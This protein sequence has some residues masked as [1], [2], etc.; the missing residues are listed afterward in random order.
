MTS[1]VKRKKIFV[2]FG[3]RPEAIKMA[4]VIKSLEQDSHFHVQVALSAQHRNLLDQVLRV[5]GVK[6]QVDMN[7]MRPGQSLTDITVGVMTQMV[8]VL[9]RLKPDMVLVHGD[10]TTSMAGTMAAFYAGVPVGHVEAG[11]RTFD[12]S[13]P[14]PEEANRQLTDVLSTLYF[15]PTP[16]SKMNLIREHRNPQNIFVT[17]NTVIDALLETARRPRPFEN[18]EL[19]KIIKR[20]HEDGKKMIL[21]TAHR[22]ENFGKPF[23][24][25]FQS[26]KNL[27]RAFPDN[28]WIYPVHPNPHVAGLAHRILGGEPRIHLLDPLEYTDLVLAMQASHLVVT[29]SGG[30][31]EEAPSLGK[32]VLVLRDVTERPEAVQAGTVR[33]VGTD[34]KK[35]QRE[36]ERLIKDARYYRKMANAVNPYGDGKA[37][38]RIVQAIKWFF[39]MTPKKPK[40]F[41]AR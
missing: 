23:E 13:R 27:C 32:P 18:R 17:G 11:L 25:A 29:D 14:F 30:L 2:F 6:A 5:F 7:L 9:A 20:I 33:L 22:R 38:N 36:F 28:E 15:C 40:P 1:A 26:I 10:T 41:I 19:G 21:M 16:M 24:E 39:G 31:Q 35:I 12:L 3:T 37:G 8:P 34:R 4:P